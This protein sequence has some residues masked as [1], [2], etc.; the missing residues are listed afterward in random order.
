MESYRPAP[1]MPARSSTLADDLAM[2]V[3]SAEKLLPAQ[4]GARPQGSGA[5]VAL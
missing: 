3:A 2:R 4:R 1:D 5:I